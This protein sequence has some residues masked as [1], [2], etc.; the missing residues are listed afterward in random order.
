MYCIVNIQVILYT[1]VRSGSQNVN[2][3]LEVYLHKN[4]IY[5]DIYRDVTSG[6]LSCCIEIEGDDTSAMAI[7]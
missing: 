7:S 1:C 4:S 3:K 2:P 6:A 5:E